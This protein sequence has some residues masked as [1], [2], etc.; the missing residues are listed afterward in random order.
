MGMS[1]LSNRTQHPIECHPLLARVSIPM[2]IEQR[3][4]SDIHSNCLIEGRISGCLAPEPLPSAS[5][6]SLA[7]QVNRKVSLVHDPDALSTRLNS[8]ILA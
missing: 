5:P 3:R 8:V 1:Y 6:V 4:C 7:R 2:H